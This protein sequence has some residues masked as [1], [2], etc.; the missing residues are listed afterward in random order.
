VTP[1]RAPQANA[2]VERLVGTLRRECF[3]HCIAISERHVRRVLREYVPYYNECAPTS[4]WRDSRPSARGP[5]RRAQARSS[6][7]PSSGDSI[8]STPGP[9]RDRILRRHSFAGDRYEVRRHLGDGATKRVFLVRD[10]RLDREVALALVRTE[11]LDATGRERV[12]RE[13]Q[14]MGRLGAHANLV[15]VHDSSEESGQP[16]IVEVAIRRGET[17]EAMRH[18]DQAAELFQQY[19]AK[20]YFDQVIAKKLELQGGAGS[21]DSRATMDVLTESIGT[22]R[23]DLASL[24]AP[25]GTASPVTPLAVF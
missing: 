16:Y 14:S 13:A 21:T 25:A 24:A 23:P 4:L 11:G 6:R 18:L 22:E 7:A 15:T 1:Y 8:T 9:Q 20:L 17:A 12:A 19:G 3:D 5:D 10:T 2:I